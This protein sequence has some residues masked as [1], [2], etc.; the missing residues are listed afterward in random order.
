MDPSQSDAHQLA[1]RLIRRDPIQP[2]FDPQNIR[3]GN[4]ILV[5][6]RMDIVTPSAQELQNSESESEPETE[7]KTDFELTEKNSTETEEDLTDEEPSINLKELMIGPPY[8]PRPLSRSTRR[9]EKVSVSIQNL[10]ILIVIGIVKLSKRLV[11]WKLKIDDFDLWFPNVSNALERANWY[12]VKL[13]GRDMDLLK[14]RFQRVIAGLGKFL[15]VLIGNQANIL[16]QEK[17]HQRLWNEMNRLCDLI[18]QTDISFESFR[19]LLKVFRNWMSETL[20]HLISL[21]T[22]P[23]NSARSDLLGY[24]K[25]TE[26]NLLINRLN[27]IVRAIGSSIEELGWAIRFAVRAL[28]SDSKPKRARFDLFS[29]G[30]DLRKE[31]TDSSASYQDNIAF[32]SSYLQ[33]G[34]DKDEAISPAKVLKCFSHV[35]AKRLSNREP[36]KIFIS[37]NYRCLALPQPPTP[38]RRRLNRSLSG[39][40]W[41][42]GSRGV[43]TSSSLSRLVDGV[44]ARPT[45]RTRSGQRTL[46]SQ[47]LESSI[48]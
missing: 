3:S 6:E 28:G 8:H 25:S 42:G 5:L 2:T 46:T 26:T 29:V 22:V 39:V 14:F 44:G 45:Y 13:F 23:L 19:N 31:L 20:E 32:M 40:G 38:N 47:G 7:T 33:M 24:V 21:H 12:L 4:D 10:S 9:I 1:L 43:S 18:Q 16:E 36:I 37:T 15:E 27:E 35:C 48:S 11:Y 30:T 34:Q 17:G 41:Y